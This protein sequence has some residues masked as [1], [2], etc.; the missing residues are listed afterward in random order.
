MRS[1]VIWAITFYRLALSP[2][3]PP[4]CRFL[5]TCSEYALEAVARFGVLRGGLLALWR[6][7]RCHPFARGGFDPVPLAFWPRLRAPRNA[8]SC[9][10]THT[11]RWDLK[12]N[13][14]QTRNP[15]RGTLACRS[16]RLEFPVSG[17]TP[18]P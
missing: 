17:Q 13:G 7:V 10:R 9:R 2:L 4:C 12:D 5:P 14:K 11:Y 8:S 3:K 18:G 15:G 16:G 6:L 1:A